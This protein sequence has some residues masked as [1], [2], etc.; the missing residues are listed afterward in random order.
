[1]YLPAT[2]VATSRL[3]WVEMLAGDLVCCFPA[4]VGGDA[5]R[6]PRGGADSRWN[7]VGRRTPRGGAEDCRGSLAT[8]RWG[9]SLS[10]GT[11]CFSLIV[12]ISRD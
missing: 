11:V 8:S 7:V 6:R 1:V 10:W 3:T 2:S 12:E 9:G 5:R 4:D